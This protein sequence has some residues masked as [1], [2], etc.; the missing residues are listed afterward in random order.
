MTVIDYNGT[1]KWSRNAVKERYA[2]HAR[3][4]HVKAHAALIPYESEHEGTRRIYPIMDCV[5][6]AIAANDA[7]AVEIGVE[8]IEDDQK[9]PFGKILKSNTP[10]ALRRANLSPYHEECI[11]HCVV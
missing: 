4:F 7:A 3:R 11:R 6:E 5:I 10:G 8:F 2:G 1:G 9:F